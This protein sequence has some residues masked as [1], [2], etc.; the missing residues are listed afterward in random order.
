MATMI[1]VIVSLAAC[2]KN[3]SKSVVA[4][5]TSKLSFQMTATNANLA[6]LPSDSTSLITGLTWTAGTANVGKFAFEAR[7]S[8]VSINIFSN[9]LTNVDLVALTPLQTYVT[10]DTGVY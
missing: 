5:G 1:L 3:N 10:L 6:S 9:N 4:S 8:G 7:R 2:K